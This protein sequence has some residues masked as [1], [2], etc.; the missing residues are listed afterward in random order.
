MNKKLIL[1][2]VGAMAAIAAGWF[3][4]GLFGGSSGGPPPMPGMEGERPPAAV[5][6][7][8][9]AERTL[10]PVDEYIAVV[11]PV[12]DVAVRAEVPGT[13]D[14]VHF[15]EGGSVSEGDLLFTIDPR[16]Y[17]AAVD[18]AQAELFRAQKLYDRMKASDVRSVSA[19]DLESAESDL[20]RARAE[21][22]RAQVNL[23]YTEIRAPVSGRIGAANTTRGNYVSPASGVLAR[24][25]QIDPVR[26]TF[27]LTDRDYLKFRRQDLSGAGTVRV[28][29]VRL[30]DGTVFPLTG[31]KEFDD[32]VV[33]P[34][35]G[36]IAVR[37]L[38]D[39]PDGLLVPGGYVTALLRD[40]AAEKGLRIPQKSLLVDQQGSYVLCVDE[41][42]V[43]SEVRIETGPQ[44]GS[45]VVVIS[46][47]HEE[48]RV[49]TD[50]L[51]KAQPGATVQVIE[52]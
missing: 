10:E 35:T 45:D 26:V 48:D 22:N 20:L 23:D 4:R 9:L 52:K 30:P 3:L 12:E 21:L 11:E 51:Q 33:N 27:S 37:Y 31:K 24:I 16:T 47:L 7:Q 1:K 15:T 17:Q 5:T 40:R 25:V 13:I 32:N 18:A 46:G 50:G 42:G 28:A 14:E 39:N 36:T 29:Q 19:S 8:V 43:V 41:E 49:I 38:F 34:Q 44:I 2:Y 6:V